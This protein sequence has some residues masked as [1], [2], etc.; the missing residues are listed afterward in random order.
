MSRLDNDRTFS[1]DVLW[2]EMGLGSDEGDDFRNPEPYRIWGIGAEFLYLGMQ[3]V[4]RQR[5]VERSGSTP[6]IAA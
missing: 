5:R 3:P 2:L 6:S 1:T 4:K